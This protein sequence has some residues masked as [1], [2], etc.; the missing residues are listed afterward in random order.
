MRLNFWR[1]TVVLMAVLMIGLGGFVGYLWR[2]VLQAQAIEFSA[3]SGLRLEQIIIKGRINTTENDLMGAINIP[4]H[5]PILTIDLQR[6]HDDIVALG[7][8]KGVRV[9]RTLPTKLIVTLNERHALAL[10]QDDN[11]HQV[12]D[13]DGEIIK[14]I[15]AEAFT[16]LPVV[17]GPN[18]PQNAEAILMLLKQ[19]QQLFADVWSLTYQS[20]RR[21]DVYLRNNI[22][23]QLPETDPGL[24]WSK[25][26]KMDREHRLTQRDVVNIDL[27]VPNKLVIRPSRP[28]ASKGSST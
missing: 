1:K 2:G 7:W 8:V 9:E 16:H 23:I 3:V 24:A 17:K 15:E 27:R 6:V 25:L 5:H 26:A 22:R 4:W 12:I 11:G 21:W 19:E 28:T 20:N 14:N 18:A 13:R 10:Y